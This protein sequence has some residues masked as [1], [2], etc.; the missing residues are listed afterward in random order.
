[1]LGADSWVP[2]DEKLNLCPRMYKKYDILIIPLVLF[3]NSNGCTYVTFL[4]MTW[5][6]IIVTYHLLPRIKK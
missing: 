2:K 1:M 6:L 4:V 3:V 5:K